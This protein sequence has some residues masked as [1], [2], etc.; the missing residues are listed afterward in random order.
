MPYE[1]YSCVASWRCCA[2]SVMVRCLG[3]V[4]GFSWFPWFVLILLLWVFVALLFEFVRRGRRCSPRAR[5]PV[6]V[7]HLSFG[8][9]KSASAANSGRA[10]NLPPDYGRLLSACLGD[11]A[12]VARLVNYELSRD[13]ALSYSQAVSLA[14]ARISED[15][16]QR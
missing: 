2:I 16:W 13:S 6:F 15:R 1:F 12:K 3:V 7:R 9:F 4:M 11:H 8:G 10:P 14:Y 5:F